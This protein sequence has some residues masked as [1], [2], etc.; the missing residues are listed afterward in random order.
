MKNKTFS[1]QNQ[2]KSF[3]IPLLISLVVA[4]IIDTFIFGFMLMEG[5]DF[6][7]F[8]IFPLLIIIF[9]LLFLGC[10]IFSN[11]RFKYT[12]IQFVSYFLL[13]LGS[14]AFVLYNYLF[15]AKYEIA[16]RVS[17]FAW[18]IMHGLIALISL[19][20]SI[21]ASRNMKLTKKPI[22]IGLLILLFAFSSLFSMHLFNEGVFGQGRVEIAKT[23]VYQYHENEDCYEVVDALK[24]KGNTLVIPE[25][26]NDKDVLYL[27]LEVFTKQDVEAIR[28][29]KREEAIR[30]ANP[31]NILQADLNQ[32][33]EI[34]AE[35]ENLKEI[36]D[37]LIK[38]NNNRNGAFLSY[39][40]QFYPT[41]LEDD[42]VFISFAYDE[43][44]Y[45]LLNHQFLDVQFIHK[46]DKFDYDVFNSFDILMHRDEHD[47]NDLMWNYL[48]NTS[49]PKIF[50]GFYEDNNLIKDNESLT[51]NYQDVRLVFDHIYALDIQDSNDT[52]Y[53]MD[54]NCSISET[55]N[56]R[57]YPY[58]LVT[59]DTV[60]DFIDQV[61]LREGFT[62]R[63]DEVNCS[64]KVSDITD[65][66]SFV[67]NHSSSYHP[68]S[69]I[70]IKPT[71]T[72]NAPKLNDVLCSDDDQT[73]I[74][75]E[76]I[77]YSMEELAPFIDGILYHYEWYKEDILGQLTELLDETYVSLKEGKTIFSLNNAHPNS[78]GRYQLKVEA[79]SN[80][81]TSL[82]SSS[83]Y[84]VNPIINKRT[85]DFTWDIPEENEIIYKGEDYF[86]EIQCDYEK[87]QVINDDSIK[88]EIQEIEAIHVGTYVFHVSL[89]RD[90]AE[91]YV[92]S[93]NTS[94]QSITILPKEIT[95]IWQETR[96]F[97]YDG[98]LHEIKVESIDGEV[99]GE[100]EDILNSLEYHNNTKSWVSNETQMT[101][102]SLPSNSDYT[103]A[104]DSENA[105]IKITK[106]PLTITFENIEKDYDGNRIS[107]SNI[108]YNLGGEG[109]ADGDTL[110]KVIAFLY[111]SNAFSA[112]NAGN[113]NFEFDDGN[114]QAQR[115]LYINYQITIVDGQLSI[116]QKEI[117]LNWGTNEFFYNGKV[118]YSTV[119]S[120]DGEVGND[121]STILANL[122]YSHSNSINVGENYQV[123][124]SFE[125]SNSGNYKLG[126]TT[127]YTY[128]IK[129]RLLIIHMNDYA[130]TYDGK[131]LNKSDIT[132]N[133]NA[134]SDSLGHGI[135]S[136]DD[137]NE[138]FTFE[139]DN[140]L[141][142]STN[143]GEY[144]MKPTLTQQ[145]KYKNYN[146]EFDRDAKF[147]IKQRNVSLVFDQTKLIYNGKVQYPQIM[148]VSGD[149]EGSE[150]KDRIKIG[151]TSNYVNVG[152]YTLNIQL[153]EQD[154]KN[155]IVE[156]KEFEITSAEV[157]ITFDSL[158]KD[159]DG[160]TIDSSFFTYSVKGLQNNEQE[161]DIFTLDFGT[162]LETKEVGKYS[163]AATPK[164]VDEIK[165]RNYSFE[166]ET[167]IL[168]ITQ[169]EL[170]FTWNSKEEYTLGFDNPC[171]PKVN[172]YESLITY[173]FYTKGG[174]PLETAP[175]EVG[176][177]YV[178]IT[179]NDS[180][181]YKFADNEKT[182]AD[183]KIV[184]TEE[185]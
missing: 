127:T 65:F 2:L 51:R 152:K 72:L 155:Y 29:E 121:E 139:W 46:G 118:Q 171:Y 157:T 30:F 161:K 37:E 160:K 50:K 83:T 181:H 5:Y 130:K 149:F 23:L 166:I 48:K 58:K 66:K 147:I 122:K 19:F 134:T 91:K 26:F 1:I 9:D 141:L 182:R 135:A 112:V 125:D 105:E 137:Q 25:K 56:G 140:S 99:P 35:K 68:G 92:I 110:E 52:K 168:T 169:H 14:M 146:I 106:R 61:S 76:D 60:Q 138:I 184:S 24:G 167:G 81:I 170:T 96:T 158:E 175:S 136:T 117:T 131:G 87:G 90:A 8:G 150:F 84:I 100:E 116:K 47:S 75:G 144:E 12:I 45:Q 11:F 82:T 33:I 17:L 179:L 6:V 3:K 126:G 79:Y 183:F 27:N 95:C 133:F 73:I 153:D 132:Y 172:E 38:V 107:S 94:S 43:E 115:S 42:E 151:D 154:E 16:T 10:I 32:D 164:A 74:Y 145:E 77:S 21:Y 128:K 15:G 86:N 78:T 185:R 18:L 31:E 177:Y 89:T 69:M 108:H 70:H 53:S 93:S 67:E 59:L 34:Y 156:G 54:Y 114:N 129:Q 102:V 101:I 80:D 123:T 142:T 111:N 165:F 44:V 49:N 104:Q 13:I 173:H 97:M 98:T 178:E 71:W 20:L 148:R 88:F 22:M 180:K 57:T 174:E 85:L 113:Y 62:L 176:E 41:S 103:I 119:L 63:W 143:F 4:L 55:Y 7:R 39:V 120:V 159:Y 162:L 64:S 28:F 124:A 36:R 40:N 109:L 163:I